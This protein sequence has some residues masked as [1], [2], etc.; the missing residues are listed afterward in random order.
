[1]HRA[2]LLIRIQTADG[3]AEGDRTDTRREPELGPGGLVL[4]PDPNWAEPTEPT[5]QGRTRTSGALRTLLHRHG[6]DGQARLG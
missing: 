6:T 3:G 2:R 5:E 4:L 1:M